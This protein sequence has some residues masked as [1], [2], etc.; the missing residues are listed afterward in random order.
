MVLSTDNNEPH[1]VSLASEYDTIL[2]TDW[3]KSFLQLRLLTFSFQKYNSLTAL[4]QSDKSNSW[5]QETRHSIVLY[6]CLV[7]NLVTVPK[8]GCI[9]ITLPVTLANFLGDMY[10]KVV[11]LESNDFNRDSILLK[12]MN[13]RLLYVST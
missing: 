12:G 10:G 4:S 11:N 6:K 3:T 1:P 13:N 7:I 9:E 2:G 8:T 5:S